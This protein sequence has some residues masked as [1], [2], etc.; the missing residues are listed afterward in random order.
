MTR[1]YTVLAIAVATALAA[2]TAS[3]ENAAGVDTSGWACES[4]P[5]QDDYEAEAQLGVLYADEDSAKFGEYNGLDEKGAYADVSAHGG[6]RAESGT[7]FGYELRDAG[8]DTREA[9][10]VAGR[11]GMLEAT[12]TYDELP[13]RVWDTTVTPWRR[14]GND[15]LVLPQGWVRAGSTAG[16]AALDGSLAG[17][18]VGTDRTTLGAGLGYLFGSNLELFADYSRQEIEGNRAGTANFLFQALQYPEPVDAAHDQFEVGATWRWK[19]GFARLSWYGS[20]YDNALASLTFDNPY[21]PAAPDSS[22]G[23]KALAP[24][25]KAHSFALDGNFLLPWWNGALSYRLAEGTMEQDQDFLPFSTSP[26]L[27]AVATLPRTRLRGDVSTSH[28]RATLSLRPLSRLRAR[29]G[30]RYDERDDQ[31]PDFATAGYVESD[32]ATHGAASRSGYGYERT[33]LEGH[34]DLRVVDWLSVGIGADS[35]KVERSNQATAETKD[36]RSYVELR[37]RPW[38]SIELTGRYG[39]SKLR[40]GDYTVMSGPIPENPLLR[41]FNQTD[42]DRDFGEARLGWSL[43]RFAVAIEGSYAFDDYTESL[44]GLNSSRD[45]RYG[46]TASWAATDDVSLYVTGSYQDIVTTQSGEEA[47]PGATR[48]WQAVHEDEFAMGGGGAVWRKVAGSKVDLTLDYTFARS[49]GAINTAVSGPPGAGGPFPDLKTELNSL[50]LGASYAVSDRLRVN[51][52]WSWEDYDSADWQLAGVDPATVPNLL[53][54]GADPYEYSANVI[55][56]SFT[57]RFG[58]RPGEEEASE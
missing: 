34:A 21:L 52:A 32:S 33:R 28:Y 18:K 51:V 27:N 29:I 6:S 13:H 14:S 35:D 22:T 26:L 10:F 46:G 43:G 58:R 56:L 1:Q 53:G 54:M 31:T 40:A 2:A 12:L 16:M 25:N 19:R 8:L 4:C 38:G 9:R 42:R 57:Y 45:Y 36:D 41:K 30:Y 47:F 39:Q 37:L 24:D 3:A 50:R 48:P 11:E 44:Y 20:S 5:F 7:Y 49:E 23:R 15:T 55:G 17:V